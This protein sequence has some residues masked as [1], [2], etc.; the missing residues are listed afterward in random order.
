MSLD[1]YAT[2]A[3]LAAFWRAIGSDESAR[4]DDLLEKSSNYLR[5][6]AANNSI[7]LDAKIAAD[8]TGLFGKTVQTITLASV[9]RAMSTPIDA[10]PADQWSQS[11]SP[12]SETMTFTNPSNDLY[13]KSN[14]MQL[15][16]FARISGKSQFGLLR[17]IR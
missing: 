1:P 5:Q 4:A 13:F 15:L 14:E 16:G 11:A 12:Y 10:P 6:I 8:T 17:G 7:D 3:D 2:T 9:K